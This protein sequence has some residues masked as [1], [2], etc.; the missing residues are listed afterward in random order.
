V[1]THQLH[2]LLTAALLYRYF[3]ASLGGGWIDS[4]LAAVL[5]NPRGESVAACAKAPP[6][7]TGTFPGVPV[8]DSNQA[9]AASAP[10]LGCIGA[11][12]KLPPT[13]GCPVQLAL[14]NRVQFLTTSFGWSLAA[15]VLQETTKWWNVAGAQLAK[16]AVHMCRLSTTALCKAASRRP[17]QQMPVRQ[18]RLLDS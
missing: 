15:L 2:V 7:C 5:N 13:T 6:T 14:L 9:D 17:K 4:A 18:N 1:R 10:I 8:Y 11:Q 12:V 16:A 3:H